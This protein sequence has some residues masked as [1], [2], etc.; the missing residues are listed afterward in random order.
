MRRHRVIIGITLIMLITFQLW[1]EDPVSECPFDVGHG[2]LEQMHH[3]AESLRQKEKYK[4]AFNL[5]LTLRQLQDSTEQ[6]HYVRHIERYKTQNEAIGMQLLNK[7]LKVQSKELY[8]LIFALLFFCILLLVMILI[9]RRL[10]KQ[11][12][13]AKEKAERSDHLKSAFLANMNHEIRTPLNAIAG[14]SQLL[15]DETDSD[16]SSQYIN[17]IKGNNELLLHLLNDVLDISKIESDTIKFTYSNVYLPSVINDLYEVVRLQ[18]PDS[19]RLIKDSVPEI[20][21]QTDQNRLVQILSNLL[22]NA[23]KHT[24]KGEVRIGYDQNET[25]KVRFYVSDTGEGIST[26]LQQTIFERFMQAVENHSKGVGLGLA[27]C[28]GFVDHLGGEIGVE[29]TPGKGSTFWFTLPLQ[30]QET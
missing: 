7:E 21:I 18:I 4:E 20:Y 19:I 16:I 17:I 23:V 10:K 29:S 11:L 3:E 2:K 6:E 12:L 25:D 14:F 28:K 8:L 27:L 30:K 22:S 9:N 15:V 24:I 13:L 1:A 5:Y 26:E